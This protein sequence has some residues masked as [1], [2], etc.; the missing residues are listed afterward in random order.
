MIANQSNNEMTTS[1]N[2]NET[3]ANTNVNTA[4]TVI[5]TDDELELAFRVLATF[6]CSRCRRPLTK[7]SQDSKSHRQRNTEPHVCCGVAHCPYCGKPTKERCRHL[8]SFKEY[9]RWSIPGFRKIVCNLK[10]PVWILF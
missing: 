3:L 9:G 4:N 2:T 7:E 1:A 8:V 5:A 6:S 10:V